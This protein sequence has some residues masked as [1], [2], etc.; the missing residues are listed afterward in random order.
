M[1]A[2]SAS[3]AAL[4]TRDLDR[5]S[6]EVMAYPNEA[7]LWR[8]AGGIANSGGTLA[9][10]LAGNLQHFIGTELGKTDYVRDRDREFSARGVPR[11][12]VTEAISAARAVVEEVVGSLSDDALQGPWPGRSPLGD[13]ATVFSML[14]HLS[15]HLMYHTGQVN[16][17]RRLLAPIDAG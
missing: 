7:A 3:L 8:L 12:D 14:L 2:V 13:G 10:H 16:Y 4:M 5:L 15:G 17:H 9:L 11:A 1:S 6:D